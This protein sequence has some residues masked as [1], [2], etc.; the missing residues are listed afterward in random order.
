VLV[1]AVGVAVQ[2]L[3]AARNERLL[4]E[5]SRPANLSPRKL[6]TNP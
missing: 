1:V 3:V 6:L 2:A 5:I 4:L